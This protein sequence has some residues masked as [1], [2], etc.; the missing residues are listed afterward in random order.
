MN[1][2]N[3]DN[4]NDLIPVEIRLIKFSPKYGKDKNASQN[5][6]CKNIM[7]YLKDL[8]SRYKCDNKYEK[9]PKIIIFR[10][11][12]WFDYLLLIFHPHIRCLENYECWGNRGYGGVMT[13]SFV[14]WTSKYIN[15]KNNKKN[16]YYEL[17]N[18][19]YNHLGDLCSN[20]N[21]KELLH[22]IKE[23]IIFNGKSNNL[24]NY[25]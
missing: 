11:Y 13:T 12:G 24:D 1:S 9:Q 3:N 8:K 18:K 22:C 16:Y 14:L 4:N 5:R 2:S 21:N 23:E 17:I 19:I 6:E 7:K 10:C 25:Y 15:I 20:K